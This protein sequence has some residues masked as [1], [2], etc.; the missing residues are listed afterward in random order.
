M[1]GHLRTIVSL[2]D[3]AANTVLSIV[4]IEVATCGLEQRARG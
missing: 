2:R 4:K 3:Y 1:E